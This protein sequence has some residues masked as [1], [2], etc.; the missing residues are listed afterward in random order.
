M[1]RR[2][3]AFGMPSFVLA[4]SL[5]A[6]PVTADPCGPSSGRSANAQSP[7]AR[8]A[9]N[10]SGFPAPLPASNP[11][12]SLPVN[13]RNVGNDK[14][15]TDNS[16]KTKFYNCFIALA[17][18]AGVQSALAQVTNLGIAPAGGQVVLFWPPGP[19]NYVVQGTTNLA[20][21]NWVLAKDAVP[22]IAVTVSNTSPARFF[23][24]ADVV[25]A[26]MALIPGG[27]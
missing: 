18:L 14:N 15:Q 5:P 4:G 7:A 25:P 23:R 10:H 16:M 21:P 24:L 17:F 26:G 3:L 8:V 11:S 9:C 19:T 20:S 6:Q 12:S 1:K 2:R 22:L 13:R 27:P